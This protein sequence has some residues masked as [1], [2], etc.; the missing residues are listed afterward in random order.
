M[1]QYRVGANTDDWCAKCKLTLAHVIEAVFNER[2]K[3]VHCN[4]C[5]SKHNYRGHAPGEKPLKVPTRRAI[6]RAAAAGPKIPS[7]NVKAS[8]YDRLMLG[9]DP[10]MADA[11]SFRNLYKQGDLL[12]H[13]QFGAGLVMADKGAHKMDVIFKI[14]PKTLVHGRV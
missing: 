13:P 1:S 9:R 5:G 3:R 14:G 7:A 6:A 10:L 12:R 2:P 8:D 4:T 11:Y